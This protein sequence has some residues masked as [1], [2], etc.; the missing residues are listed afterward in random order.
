MF[1]IVVSYDIFERGG[2]VYP[3]DGVSIAKVYFLQSLY[4]MFYLAVSHTLREF[5]KGG[6]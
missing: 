2:Y 4:F 1:Y 3:N 6:T 5:Q